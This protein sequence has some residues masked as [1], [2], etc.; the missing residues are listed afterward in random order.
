MDFSI[1]PT[2]ECALLAGQVEAEELTGSARLSK[3]ESHEQ[4]PFVQR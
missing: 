3:D 4:E 1:Y 2:L